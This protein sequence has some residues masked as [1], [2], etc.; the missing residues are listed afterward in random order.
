MPC[1]LTSPGTS[2]RSNQHVEHPLHTSSTS[3]PP[4]PLQT[5][6]GACFAAPLVNAEEVV[7]AIA[8]VDSDGGGGDGGGLSPCYISYYERVALLQRAG[9]RVAMASV[10]VDSIDLALPV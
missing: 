7:D 2:D 9:A 6:C 4:P 8:F 1:G 3:I 10:A 5:R